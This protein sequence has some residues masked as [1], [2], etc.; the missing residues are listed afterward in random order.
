MVLCT[1]R[2]AFASKWAMQK[3][4]NVQSI[5]DFG[6]IK[7]GKSENSLRSH[8]ILKD[9][10]AQIWNLN[11][12]E[13]THTH[14]TKKIDH[15]VSAVP[16]WPESLPLLHSNN[17]HTQAHPKYEMK[18]HTQS[19][20]AE[21][22]VWRALPWATQPC[23]YQRKDRFPAIFYQEQQMR[24]RLKEPGKHF[25]KTFSSKIRQKERLRCV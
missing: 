8:L 20:S 2:P 18:A 4:L 22:W 15:T 16:H 17:H 21:Q 13:N 25:S 5:L 6:L 12:P 24:R 10:R 14:S 9:S 23:I 3:T 7:E 19:V 11:T 1:I